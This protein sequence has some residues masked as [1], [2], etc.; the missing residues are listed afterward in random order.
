MSYLRTDDSPYK[1]TL[2][3][4]EGPLDLLLHLIRENEIDI[5]DIP[6]A[7]VTEQYLAYLSLM[8]SLDLEVAGEW[9][10]MAATLLEIKSRMLLPEDPKEQES[11]EEKIDPRLE[12]VERL[13][14]YEKFKSAA[15]V[16]REREEERAKVFGRGALELD[17]DLKP[18]IVL[19]NITA[20]DLLGM[21]QR[22]LS[23]VGEEEVTSI[24]RRKITVKIRMREIWRKIGA[25]GGQLVFQDLFDDVDSRVEVVITFLALLELLKSQQVKVKQA[26]AFAPIQIIPLTELREKT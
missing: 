13:I 1:V 20:T 25:A 23:D 17:F 22:I 9:L 12:L 19:D 7:K 11:E 24:Q 14:E 8:E 6:I 10:V 21:L 26:K 3:I 4:F 5:Y 18:T 15:N 16:F 2:G